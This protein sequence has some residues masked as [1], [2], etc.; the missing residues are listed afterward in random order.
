MAEKYKMPEEWLKQALYDIDSA[1]A[2]FKSR[3]YIYTIFLSHL[4][5][6]KILKAIYTNKF[7]KNPPR[8]HDLV[9]ITSEAGLE[10]TENAR[11]YLEF[12]NKLSVPTRYPDELSS[13]MKTFNRKAT[14]EFYQKTKEVFEWLRSTYLN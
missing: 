5:I 11:D 2:M 6:E 3:R 10:L 1:M 4:A 14:L 9:Y 13:M 12:I 7:S 8:T